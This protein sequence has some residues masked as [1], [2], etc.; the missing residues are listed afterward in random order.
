[1]LHDTPI[2]PDHLFPLPSESASPAAAADAYAATLARFFGVDPKGPP[3]RFDLVLLG[4]G[5][6]GHT[7][8]LFPGKPSLHVT[9][10]WLTASPPGVLPPPVDRVTF[11]FP[12]INAA[13]CFSATRPCGARAS[14]AEATIS[15]AWRPP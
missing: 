6:D 13:R 14:T 9:D 4:L 7:A 5:D 2:P 10:T 3:P 11:T 1:L 8:S 12:T 15:E